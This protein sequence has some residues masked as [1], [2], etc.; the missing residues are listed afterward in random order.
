MIVSYKTTKTIALFDARK[1][2]NNNIVR[3]KTTH[4]TGVTALD[5][6]V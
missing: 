6:E 3:P 1:Q 2:L 4:K 5:Q